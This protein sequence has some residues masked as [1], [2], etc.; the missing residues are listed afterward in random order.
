MHR[1]ARALGLTRRNTADLRAA[2]EVT[3]AM[4]HLAPQDPVRYDFC[5]TRLGIRRD[6]DLDAFVALC[7]GQG[8]RAPWW[9]Q[10]GT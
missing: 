7:R 10:E 3:V 8:G 9:L 4:A 5:L 1:M 2:R 6:A